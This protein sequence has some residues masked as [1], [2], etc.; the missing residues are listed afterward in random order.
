[1]KRKPS[2]KRVK[3]STSSRPGKPAKSAKVTKAIKATKS[4][5]LDRAKPAQGS[6]AATDAHITYPD[7]D[8]RSIGVV[9]F[10]GNMAPAMDILHR[11]ADENP[12]IHLY[13][14]GFLKP[15]SGRGIA[16]KP[17]AF[18][19]SKVDLIL[20]LGGDGTFLSAARLVRGAS[21]PILGVNLGRVGFLADVSL[22]SLARILDEILR[23][24]YSYRKRM[25]VQVEV[26][27][28]G[29]R[30]LED[31]AMN[32]VAF[33]GQMGHQMVDLRVTAQGR[34]LTDYWVDGLLVSTPTGSTAYSLSAGGPIIHPSADSLLLT[35]MNPTSLSVR[36]L[37]LPDYM[38][39]SVRSNLGRTLEVN[40][41][42]DGRNQFRL[43]PE[44]TVFIRKH[45]EGVR[46]VRP[47]GSSFFESLS[48]KLGW[49][50]SRRTR[51]SAAGAP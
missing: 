25:L 5:V 22:D 48:S 19:S 10:A 33:T 2:A 45:R 17:D 42:V 4:T 38:V 15:F 32:D 30:L 14:N 9:A 34:F 13:V 6:I 16:V 36:P 27:K 20:S 47:K 26:F 12:S 43:K 28:G 46:L 21:T 40:M 35:P 44:H 24:E 23:R 37:I 41:F 49:T 31:I 51:G 3:A 7:H 50:G 11:W 29:K 8:V 18:L 1:M 39:V